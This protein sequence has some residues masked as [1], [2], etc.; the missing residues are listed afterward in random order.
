MHQHL[1][2]Q[3]PME[4]VPQAGHI[5]AQ[6]GLAL[7]FLI[8]AFHA[9]PAMGQLSQAR[10]RGRRGQIAPVELGLTLLLRQRAFADEPTLGASR[11]R[12]AA[13]DAQGAEVL[14]QRTRTAHA[15]S[16]GVPGG[17]R[18]TR[19]HRI[20]AMQGRHLHG[21]RLC[22]WPARLLL[23][24]QWPCGRLTDFRQQPHAQAAGDAHYTT[25]LPL[26]QPVEEVGVVAV[27]GI[28]AHQGKRNPRR[29][30]LIEQQQGQLR[31]GVKAQLRRDPR[32]RPPRRVVTPLLGQMELAQG[33]PGVGSM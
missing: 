30:G 8:A 2:G 29:P 27:A 25:H 23:A 26:L 16:N 17:L 1:D 6:A 7:A 20:G 12:V 10:Q 4:A 9:R 32:G 14:G 15:P 33:R 21:V 19:Q 22:T 13:P 11:V 18:L 5:V 24:G 31:L 3:L 28:G